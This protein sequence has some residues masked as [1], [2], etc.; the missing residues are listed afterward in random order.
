MCRDKKRDQ[1]ANC[2]SEKTDDCS[3]HGLFMEWAMAGKPHTT[4]KLFKIHGSLWKKG[5]G[6][7]VLACRQKVEGRSTAGNTQD[8]GRKS[9]ALPAHG[10]ESSL[11]KRN[12]KR[13]SS[14]QP[15]SPV[16]AASS[17]HNEK[18]E[19]SMQT[20]AA[21]YVVVSLS[22]PACRHVMQV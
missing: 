18:I 17:D 8:R 10:R 12:E 19:V 20:A 21:P 7:G 22:S 13:P 2:G 4:K 15:G 6:N 5:R 11:G 9:S 3:A 16:A 1:K 14:A